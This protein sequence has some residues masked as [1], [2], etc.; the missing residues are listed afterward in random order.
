MKKDEVI[1][2]ILSQNYCDEKDLRYNTQ[3]K[4]LFSKDDLEQFKKIKDGLID[5]KF[6][7]IIDLPLKTFDSKHIFFVKGNYLLDILSGYLSMTL[8]DY[9]ENEKFLIQRTSVEILTARIFSEIEGTL[10]IENVKTTH[11]RIKEICEKSDLKEKNDVIIKNMHDALSFI[12]YDLPEFNKENLYKLYNILSKDCLEEEDQLNGGYYRNGAVTIGNGV[13]DRD[14]GAPFEKIEELMD[15]LFKFVAENKDDKDLVYWLPHICHYYI[16]YVH[17]YFDYNGRT[18]RMVSFWITVLL[19]SFSLPLF[20]SEAINESK[21]KYYK[22][23]SDTRHFNNDLTY[24]F[25]FIYNSATQFSL[26]YKNI[27]YAE[28]MLAKSGDFLTNA[29]KLY[30]KKILIHSPESYFNIKRFMEFLNDGISKQAAFKILNQLTD[31]GIL[32]AGTNK[33]NEKIFKVNPEYIT[34]RFN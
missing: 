18:A 14:T 15:S 28:K 20:I 3:K 34:Y 8:D 1:K 33:K 9:K 22:A 30:L 21:G 27:E 5:E 31:Y 24:F 25:G 17:P 4:Y 16:I 10:N 19:N 11:K 26:I 23:I 29:E 12:I 13:V 32:E 2:I 6:K 7:H